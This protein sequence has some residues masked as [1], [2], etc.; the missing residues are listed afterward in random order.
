MIR[1]VTQVT[2]QDLRKY[3]HTEFVGWVEAIDET[4]HKIAYTMGFALLYPSYGL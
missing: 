4:H 2:V 1:H 3:K